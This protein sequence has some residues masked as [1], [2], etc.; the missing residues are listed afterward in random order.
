MMKLDKSLNESDK[1]LGSFAVRILYIKL[2]KFWGGGG[3]FIRSKYSVYY[4]GEIGGGGGLTF[5]VRILYITL[6][7]FGGGGGFYSQ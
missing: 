1:S 5:A 6:G 3:A 7:K 2:E 4:I